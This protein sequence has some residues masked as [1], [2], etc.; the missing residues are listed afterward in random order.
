MLKS[1]CTPAL[2][3]SALGI[4]FALTCSSAWAADLPAGDYASGGVVLTLAKDGT[5]H[6]NQGK[7]TK[8]SGKYTVS[9]KQVKFTDLAGEWACKSSVV[10]TY[11]W[12]LDAG[13]LTLSKVSDTCDDRSG[14]LTHA[15]WKPQK[16]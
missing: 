3:V 14:S 1:F 13:A 11:E 15:P 12:K 7:D 2:G 5:F 4:A 6:A 9:G 16:P 10:G 8:V